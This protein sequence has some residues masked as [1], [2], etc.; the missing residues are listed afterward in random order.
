M[1]QNNGTRN[2]ER[3]SEF[4]AKTIVSKLTTAVPVYEE[5]YGDFDISLFPLIN[6]VLQNV[7]NI[8]RD[9]EMTVNRC[10][11]NVIVYGDSIENGNSNT[12]ESKKKVMK[13]IGEIDNIFSKP[14]A[15]RNSYIKQVIGNVQTAPIRFGNKE[16]YNATGAIFSV[17]DISFDITEQNPDVFEE[18]CL[19]MGTTV[20]IND[21][22]KGYFY[23]KIIQE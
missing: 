6:V 5:F 8:H 14:L 9:Q 1:Y 23:E 19:E 21:T 12:R 2:F 4:T 17:M 16:V 22:G 3:L 13:I 7:E 15:Y 10:T 20:K 11:V 18:L